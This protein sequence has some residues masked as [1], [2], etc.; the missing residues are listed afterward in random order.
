MS[1]AQSEQLDVGLSVVGQYRQFLLEHGNIET[2]L[3][4]AKCQQLNVFHQFYRSVAAP[5][6]KMSISHS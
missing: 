3:H 4:C 2:I 1:M 5:C 6:G